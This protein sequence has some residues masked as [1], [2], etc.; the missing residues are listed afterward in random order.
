[1]KITNAHRRKLCEMMY[2]AF[3]ETRQL[4][5][6]G[7][8]GQVADLEGESGQ[9]RSEAEQGPRPPPAPRQLR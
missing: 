8:A 6:A 3:L 2:W 4:G 5:W 1:M 9:V 7:K